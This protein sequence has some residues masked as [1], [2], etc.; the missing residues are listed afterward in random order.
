MEAAWSFANC[1][2]SMSCSSAVFIL[3][4]VSAMTLYFPLMW[5]MSVVNLAMAENVVIA[6]KNGV[7]S[8]QMQR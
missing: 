2:K 8:L 7:L 3:T 4:R 5:R 6:W 1:S